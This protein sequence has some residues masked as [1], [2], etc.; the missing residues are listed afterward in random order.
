MPTLRAP[1]RRPTNSGS[2]KTRAGKRKDAG[3]T[4]RQRADRR[5][6]KRTGGRT[7]RRHALHLTGYL[8]SLAQ[9]GLI[10]VLAGCLWLT[11]S[12]PNVH[13][14]AAPVRRP[15]ISLAAADGSSIHRYGDLAGDAVH[16][17]DLPPHLVQAVLA[18]E[19][20]RF[21][22]HFGL[23]GRAIAR[24]FVE[25]IRAGRIVQGG[26]T[27]S[28]QLA[29]NLFLTPDQTLMRKVQEALLALWL[30]INYDKDD[31]LSAY[32]N[33][34]YLGNGTFGVDAAARAYFGVPASQVN[35]HQ[36]AIL[37]GLLQAPSRYS[38]ARAPELAAERA[39]TVLAVMVDVGFITQ[40]EADAADAA[41]PAPRHR[42]SSGE[43]DRYFADWVV[44][45]VPSF[46]GNDPV[47]MRVTTTLDAPLQRRIEQIVTDHLAAE[48]AERNAGQAAVVI[49]RRDGGV[50]AM[51]GGRSYADSQFNRATQAWRQPG[52][53]FKPIVYLTALLD[54]MTPDDLVLD[55]PITIGNWSPQNF[56]GTF[57]GELTATQ[58]LATSANTAAVRIMQMAG[59]DAVVATA[60]RLG[61][62]GELSPNLSLA[63]GTGEV[64]LLELTA[65]YAAIANDGRAV[66]PYGIETITDRQDNSLY[67]RAG[68]GAGQAVPSWAA[69]EL[70]GMLTSVIESGTGRN[71]GFGW[72]AAGKTGTS[73][74]YRDGWFVGFTAEY[75]AGVW[76]GNDDGSFMDRVTGGGLPARIWHDVMAAAHRDLSPRPLPFLHERPIAGDEGEATGPPLTLVRAVDPVTPTRLIDIEPTPTVPVHGNDPILGTD[77]E[78]RGNQDSGGDGDDLD[79]LIGDL[80]G[81]GTE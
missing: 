44:D 49:M 19:D 37:A 18:I 31:I 41:P 34:V 7:W 54:G 32:L 75:V 57:V 62:S 42:P 13:E 67:R 48:G 46:V 50:V 69:S 60:R 58:A 23:D 33:R 11:Q 22:N 6:A 71:A 52:S 77:E 55:A 16:V 81:S 24:A 5:T 59:V 40:A 38:P 51:V 80:L 78:A 27:I 74:D 63:L 12:M 66:W 65:A 3:A 15:A 39:E 29:K 17:D 79:R 47:D 43:G 45:E 61:L 30:E 21:Y 8:A 70:M 76:V 35:L 73:Q 72:P 10:C 64:T 20:R 14:L 56:S 4:G 26:S 28:Q 68:S 9:F 25:N 2:R 1:T 53:A 36:A